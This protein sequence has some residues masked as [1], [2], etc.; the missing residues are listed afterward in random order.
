VSDTLG[1]V[2]EVNPAV[3]LNDMR[4]PRALALGRNSYLV[5]WEQADGSGFHSLQ[6]KTGNALAWLANPAEVDARTE[7]VSGSL[8]L[9]GPSQSALVLWQ[10]AGT[11]FIARF[12][13]A[14]GLWSQPAQIGEALTG[15]SSDLRAAVDGVG[16]AIAV[17][18]QRPVGGGAADLYAASLPA[19][20]SPLAAQLLESDAAEAATPALA[21]NAGGT[22]VV[23]WRQVQATQTS[24][25][26]VARRLR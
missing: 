1:L 9:A 12:G 24:P 6:S 22:A 4:N 25:S 7:G 11:L 13:F 2:L 19:G 10:Q 18:L 21:M 14:S 17:W 5:T 20:V 15:G 16:N 8:L 3:T 26:L 23:A